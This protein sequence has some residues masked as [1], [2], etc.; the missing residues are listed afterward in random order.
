MRRKRS[1]GCGRSGCWP[2]A[3]QEAVQSLEKLVTAT[4]SVQTRR[5]CRG[6]ELLRTMVGPTTD[7]VH[8]ERASGNSGKSS[9][10]GRAGHVY[11]EHSGWPSSP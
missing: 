5:W 3:C 9:H 2:R 11:C 7:H 6:V 1:N 10:I 8:S 4:E